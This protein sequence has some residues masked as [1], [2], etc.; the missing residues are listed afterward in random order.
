M[1]HKRKKEPEEVKEERDVVISTL[2]NSGVTAARQ[3][4]DRKR[5]DEEE[6]DE[7]EDE[8]YDEWGDWDED[9]EW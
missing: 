1:N 5:A 6:E 3:Q 8:Y 9:E 2:A 4:A 7:D